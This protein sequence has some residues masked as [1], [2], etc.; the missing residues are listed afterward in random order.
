MRR[1]YHRKL[2]ASIYHHAKNVGIIGILAYPKFKSKRKR[3]NRRVPLPFRGKRAENCLHN[4]GK[5]LGE[6]L[7]HEI[8]REGEGRREKVSKRSPLKS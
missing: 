4:V 8:L 6:G 7:A 3:G 1:N 5:S 2:S